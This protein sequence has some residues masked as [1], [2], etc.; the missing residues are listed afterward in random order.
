LHYQ[1]HPLELEY[2]EKK[3]EK[4]RR[5]WKNGRSLFKRHPKKKGEE[6]EKITNAIASNRPESL[7]K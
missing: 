5:A 2:T 1:N 3:D 6:K 7:L 4:E